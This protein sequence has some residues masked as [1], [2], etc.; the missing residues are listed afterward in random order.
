MTVA[1][2]SKKYFEFKQENVTMLFN[3]REI[4]FY[5]SPNNENRFTFCTK[6]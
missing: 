3:I 2:K 1:D 4:G 5:F 6:S